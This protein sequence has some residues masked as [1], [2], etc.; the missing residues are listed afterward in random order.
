MTKRSPCLDCERSEED[1]NKCL[2][3]CE[4]L[5]EYQEKLLKQ[6]LYARM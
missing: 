4:K 2:E 1:K 5:K 3:K 6:G